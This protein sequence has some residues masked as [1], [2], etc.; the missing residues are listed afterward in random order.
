[1][2]DFFPEQAFAKEMDGRDP[3]AVYRGKFHMPK[4]TK[5]EDNIYFVGIMI[6]IHLRF[7]YVRGCPLAGSW[8]LGTKFLHYV[9][10]PPF[11]K[12]VKLLFTT[13]SIFFENVLRNMLS[14]LQKTRNNI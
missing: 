14:G 12:Q 6:V 2:T 11:S 4:N 13:F 10:L 9:L 7:Y 1:M 5:G 3:L 8:F